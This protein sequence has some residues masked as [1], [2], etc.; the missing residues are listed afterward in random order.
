MLKIVNGASMSSNYD[1]IFLQRPRKDI[2]QA[3]SENSM[4]MANGNLMWLD[5]MAP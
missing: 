4:V 2:L 5:G 3:N 1:W